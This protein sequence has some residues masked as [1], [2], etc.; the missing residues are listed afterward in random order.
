[1]TTMKTLFNPETRPTPSSSAPRFD[2]FDKS[3]E[4]WA[5]YVERPNQHFVLHNVTNLNKKRAL[6]LFSLDPEMY[7]L[8]QN[9]FGELNVS[10]QA[11]ADLVYKLT[12][13]FKQ[14]THVQASRY[15][16]Y[17]C[18]METNQTYVEW[19]ATLCGIA[20]L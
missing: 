5:Q 6:L 8:L 4:N 1:M 18:Q 7:K 3:K 16:F 11:F 20:K 19:V 13:H 12:N 9:L 17:N 14:V 2:T 15:S 10:E